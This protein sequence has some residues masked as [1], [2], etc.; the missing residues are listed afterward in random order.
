VAI[1]RTGELDAALGDRVTE[2]AM[3]KGVLMVRTGVGTLKIGPPLTIPEEV[4]LE[5]VE[6]V[7]E[8]LDECIAELDGGRV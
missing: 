7:G 6:G 1:R 8:A 5:G 3:R 2:R 4:A